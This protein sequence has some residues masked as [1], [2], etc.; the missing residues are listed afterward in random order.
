MSEVP[1]AD[2]PWPYNNEDANKENLIP[3]RMIKLSDGW[4]ISP[5]LPGNFQ[6]LPNG[7]F[8]YAAY[9]VHEQYQHM[10]QNQRDDLIEQIAIETLALLLKEKP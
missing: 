6:R 9:K 10:I 4:Y 7:T 2:C 8:A 3:C 1:S 5:K